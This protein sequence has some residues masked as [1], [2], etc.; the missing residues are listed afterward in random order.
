MKQLASLRAKEGLG[1]ETINLKLR[2]GTQADAAPCGTIC[3]EAFNA[4]NTQHNFPPDFPS[5]EMVSGL[6]SMMLAHP[7]FYSRSD[8]V[9]D[10][11]PAFIDW[12][13]R[14]RE[15]AGLAALRII[16]NDIENFALI[17]TA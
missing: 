12:N 15:R 13:R 5:A 11:V 14:P 6:L 3:Y 16:E 17:F 10:A 4:I 2:A 9:P 1:I 7:Q 8:R